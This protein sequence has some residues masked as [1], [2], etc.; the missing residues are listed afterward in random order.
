MAFGADLSERQL[1]DFQ[2]EQIGQLYELMLESS[3][4]KQQF[5]IHEDGS[6]KWKAVNEE[7]HNWHVSWFTYSLW[8]WR[9]CNYTLSF[10]ALSYLIPWLCSFVSKGSFTSIIIFLEKMHRQ[11]L[12]WIT[13][14]EALTILQ[15]WKSKAQINN[16]SFLLTRLYTFLQEKT[17]LASKQICS[18]SWK[19]FSV[20][21]ALD[22]LLQRYR[23]GVLW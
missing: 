23:I 13:S 18:Y 1:R 8:T 12:S 16:A 10:N 17:S 3:K 20:Q 21:C 15:A 11:D 7:E 9:M 19:N 6:P 4:S 5:H 14:Q 22:E 2:D